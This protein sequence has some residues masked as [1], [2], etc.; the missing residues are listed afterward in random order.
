MNLFFAHFLL[1]WFLVRSFGSIT[2]ER[3]I[4]LRQV[5]VESVVVFHGGK[6]AIVQ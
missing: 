3:D 2:G 4:K 5:V 6:I 1:V